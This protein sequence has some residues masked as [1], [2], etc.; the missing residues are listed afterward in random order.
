MMHDVVLP[1]TGTLHQC[2]ICEAEFNG[3]FT[4]LAKRRW[5]HAQEQGTHAVTA[6]LF[7]SKDAAPHNGTCQGRFLPA[8]VLADEP[9]RIKALK[10]A[11]DIEQ[12][13]FPNATGEMPPERRE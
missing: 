5:K 11:H 8:H 10:L 12:K 13:Y 4:I 2:P 1:G 6:L 9:D 3:L 7:E